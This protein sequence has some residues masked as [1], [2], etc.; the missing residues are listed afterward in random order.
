MD[1]DQ[2]RP[3]IRRPVGYDLV[4]YNIETGELHIPADLVSERR[5]YCRLFSKRLFDDPEFFEHDF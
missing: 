4:V 3:D 5:F 2:C 1:H